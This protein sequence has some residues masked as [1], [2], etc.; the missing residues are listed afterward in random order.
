MLNTT[1]NRITFATVLA[2]FVA[3]CAA[4][5]PAAAS[6]RTGAI[7][8]SLVKTT[9]PAEVEGKA[10]EPKAPEGGLY[11]S[12]EG[13]LNQL[14]EDPADSEP[15]F[16]ADGHT[17]AFVRNGDVW[18]M[19][20]DGS[21]Q[22]Q[23]TSGSEIDGRPLVSPNGRYVLYER[24]ASAG[25]PRDLYTVRVGGSAAHQV[26]ASPDDDHEASI[27]P[28]GCTIDFVRSTPETGGGTAD[29]IYSMRP[30][31]IRL[32]RLTRTARIDEFAPRNLD[33]T[34]LFSRGE[35]SEG[36][37]SFA[38]IYKMDEDGKKV[39]KVIA[40]AGSSYVEDATASGRTL[41]FRR[42]QG[43]W[44]KRLG[45][46]GRKLAE[47]PDQSQTNAVFS[48]DG[49]QVAVFT[50]DKEEQSLSVID[51]STGRRAYTEVVG[52]FGGEVTTAIGPVMA[53][54]PVRR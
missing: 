10:V 36:P 6:A 46:K 21:G 53:W 17:I 42:D 52:S 54:Q 29:D 51:V 27:S 23:L 20:A 25:A 16:S 41:L 40:G 24:R 9:H 1:I 12:R 35:S 47:L 39:R 14:T 11:A 4:A 13:R 48:S 32:R 31:G 30:A 2:A 28:D 8:F 5:L 38:D 45:G 3:L 22:R 49:R 18:A 26:T 7:V 33:E 34:V 44:V 43:L 37:S 50:A 15:A 19:R